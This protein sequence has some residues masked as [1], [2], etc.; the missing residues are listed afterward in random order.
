MYLFLSCY[1]LKI[2]NYKCKLIY[3]SLKVTGKQ[4]PTKRKG[5]EDITKESH[6]ITKEESNREEINREELQN[7]Q[8][9]ITT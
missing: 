9:K 8:R 5:S 2:E 4:K 3:V 7:S 1:Q 6:Q